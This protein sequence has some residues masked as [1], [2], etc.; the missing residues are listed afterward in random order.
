[1]SADANEFDGAARLSGPDQPDR[2]DSAARGGSCGFEGECSTVGDRPSAAPPENVRP[3]SQKPEETPIPQIAAAASLPLSER[4]DSSDNG[5]PSDGADSTGGCRTARS[6]SDG[7]GVVATI[8]GISSDDEGDSSAPSQFQSG[9][10]TCSGCFGTSRSTGSGRLAQWARMMKLGV[11]NFSRSR[12]ADFQRRI[13]RGVPAE[14]RW[15]VWKAMLQLDRRKHCRRLANSGQAQELLTSQPQS[16]WKEQIFLDAPRT[17]PGDPRFDQEYQSSLI[18]VLNAYAMLNPQVGYCQGM[19]FVAGL[20]LLVSERRELEVLLVLVCLMEDLGLCG[21]YREQ[22][23]LLIRYEEAFEELVAEGLPDLARHFAKVNLQ[24]TDFLHQWFLSLY[25]HCLPFPSVLIIWDRVMC[26]GPHVLLLV[27]LALL[28]SIR[29]VLLTKQMDE[30]LD[31][32]RSLK[33]CH[34]EREA[35]KAGSLLVRRSYTL[36]LPDHIAAFLPLEESSGRASRRSRRDE[37]RHNDFGDRNQGRS[38][39]ADEYMPR[40]GGASAPTAEGRSPPPSAETR[41]RPLL[42]GHHHDHHGG[43]SSGASLMAGQ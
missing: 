35:E 13:V 29:N 28:D 15:E 12:P 4:K 9:G 26:E 39:S 22:F 41:G 5:Q 34:S 14:Y 24:L 16:S 20:L 19:S 33:Q 11:E 27:A 25:V 23:P 32:L 40:T 37:R 10:A 8:T 2:S 1:M 6:G 17:F 30:I 18:R 42:H 38:P 43:Y 21:F 36:N 7:T 31:L 3:S